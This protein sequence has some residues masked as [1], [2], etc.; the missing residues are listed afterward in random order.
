MGRKLIKE[1]EKNKRIDLFI[2]YPKGERALIV[3]LLNCSGLL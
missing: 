2:Q 1:R 3:K